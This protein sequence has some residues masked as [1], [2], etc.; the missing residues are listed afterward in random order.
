MTININASNIESLSTR[1]SNLGNVAVFVDFDN[2]YH[3]LRDFAIAYEELQYDLFDFLWELYNKDNVRI[4]KA[5]ADFDQL[6]IKLRTLQIKRVQVKQVYGNGQG[7]K[8]R[9]NASDIELSIDALESV[10]SGTDIDTF[11]FV[12][13]D[14]DM[15][16]I[17]SRMVFKG[18]KVHLYY[19]STNT[20]QYQ[21]ITEYAHI[22]EDLINYFEFDLNRNKPNYWVE[23]VKLHIDA[24]YN[25][26]RNQ[27][28][29]YG[30]N[31]LKDDL[32]NNL[33]FS[34]KLASAVIE[35]LENESIIVKHKN[36]NIEGYVL[37]EKLETI[38]QA[39]AQTQ[40]SRS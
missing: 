3:S 38:K 33:K 15:I 24:W 13:A 4:L 25:D 21:D 10:Y 17:M 20:S 31:W 1:L 5:Y 2:F 16:P 22:S 29:L 7:E 27:G 9:K 26:R 14:S 18:K 35:Y 6:S 34:P 23:T 11:V 12:T 37:L 8:N 39:F 36:G 32:K 28:K 19:L 40:I 30:G